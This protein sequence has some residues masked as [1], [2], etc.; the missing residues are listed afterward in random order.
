M[1]DPHEPDELL[2]VAGDELG[3]I[4]RDDPRPDARV[5]FQGFLQDDLDFLFLHGFP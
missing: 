2:E 3:T 1:G 5:L 4:V